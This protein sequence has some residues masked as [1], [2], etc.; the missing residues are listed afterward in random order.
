MARW[1]REPYSEAKAL[2][3]GIHGHEGHS[4]VGPPDARWIYYVKV[5]Q[6]TFVFF[7]LEMIQEYLAFYSKKVLPSSRLPLPLWHQ[8]GDNQRPFERLPLRLRKEAKRHRVVKAL[9]AALAAFGAAELGNSNESKNAVSD[10]E[11]F[12]GYG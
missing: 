10:S 7:S 3:A 11:G 1:W 4:V 6:F 5:C 2:A 12:A 9:T 8:R